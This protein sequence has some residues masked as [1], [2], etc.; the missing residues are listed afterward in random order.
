M[1]DMRWILFLPSGLALLVVG[2]IGGFL[3][4]SDRTTSAPKESRSV[5]EVRLGEPQEEI[6]ERT[7][8]EVKD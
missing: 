5:G 3:I 2:A 7:D 4:G 6:V 1:R 8:A